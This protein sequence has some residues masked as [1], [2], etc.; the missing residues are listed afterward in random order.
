MTNNLIF[1]YL[2]NFHDNLIK[3]LLD[4]DEFCIYLELAIEAYRKDKNK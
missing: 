4:P 1:Q 3:E 2:E